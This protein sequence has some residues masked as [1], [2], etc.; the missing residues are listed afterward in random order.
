LQG[1]ER[2]VVGFLEAIASRSVTRNNPTAALRDLEVNE[3]RRGMGRSGG[4]VE[5]RWGE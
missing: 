3:R 2:E 5:R 1:V 4:G